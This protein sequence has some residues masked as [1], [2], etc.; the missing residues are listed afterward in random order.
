MPPLVA[1]ALK[2]ATVVSKWLML[3]PIPIAAFKRRPLAI[4][5]T[6]ASVLF[7]LPRFCASTIEPPLA[8]RL[9]S[10]LPTLALAA[11]LIT[12]TS[13]LCDAS[14]RIA[15]LLLPNTLLADITTLPPLAA[16]TSM[17]P[18][19]LAPS[20]RA[21]APVVKVTSFPANTLI[22]PVLLTMSALTVMSPA[23]LRVWIRMLPLPLALMATLS[24]AA[25]PS[26]SV[27]VP[28]DTNTMFPLLPATK[29]LWFPSVTTP[30]VAVALKSLTLTV[31]VSTVTALSSV[32]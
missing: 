16:T 21:S 1:R 14:T 27:I 8:V 30:V 22:E 20:V 24:A 15:P 31:T 26:F 7:A 32:R 2:L 12:P 3:W 19:L 28:P 4:T 9:T 18:R 29:S 17:L 23:A 25:V 10:P 13:M 11:V 6:T 5:L